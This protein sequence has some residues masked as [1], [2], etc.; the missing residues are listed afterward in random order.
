MQNRGLQH[1]ISAS[2]GSNQL[3]LRS[4]LNVISINLLNFTF[5]SPTNLFRFTVNSGKNID[6]G[7]QLTKGYISLGVSTYRLLLA[8]WVLFQSRENYSVQANAVRI[9]SADQIY[10]STY[11]YTCSDVDNNITHFL[12]VFLPLLLSKQ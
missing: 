4:F 1:A 11:T 12:G 9:D 6:G 7:I 5:F 8:V 3:Q 2:L 10:G